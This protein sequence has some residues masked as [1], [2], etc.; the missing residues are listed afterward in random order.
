M[1]A[2]HVTPITYLI[3]RQRLSEYPNCCI[4]IRKRQRSP[5]DN[6]YTCNRVP[7][8]QLLGAQL[9]FLPN[10]S[11]PRGQLGPW[12]GINGT[13]QT[14]TKSMGTLRQNVALN[15]RARASF[16]EPVDL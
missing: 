16:F 7:V 9:P 6:S 11:P 15:P 3:E 4:Y 8:D 1:E 13:H 2:Y 14:P 12:G 10:H 5:C